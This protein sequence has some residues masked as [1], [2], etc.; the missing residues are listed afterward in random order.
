MEQRDR[1]G[2]GGAEEPIGNARGW[3]DAGATHLSVDT[4]GSRLA[5]LD[6]HIDVLASASEALRRGLA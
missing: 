1:W 6:A 3:R 5:G 2:T 4:M